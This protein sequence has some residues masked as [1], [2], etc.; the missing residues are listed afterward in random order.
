LINNALT[1]QNLHSRYL[2]ESGEAIPRIPGPRRL[3]PFS[4]S[5]GLMP[6]KSFEKDK[7]VVIIGAGLAGLTAGRL[8]AEAR[9]PYVILEADGRP[10]GLCRTETVNGFSFD[11]TG[12]LLHLK[13]GES[14]DIILGMLGQHLD[15][16]AR[17]ASVFIEGAPVPYPIQAHFGALPAP[18]AKR[19]MEDL[20]R[21]RGSRVSP[22]MAFPEWARAQF[23]ETL[24]DIFMIPYNQKLFIHPLEEMEISWTSWS[25]P[26]PTVKEVKVIAAGGKPP[27]FG[28]NATFFY[29]R[30]GGIEILPGALGGGQEDHIRNGIRVRKVNAARKTVT[31][32]GGGEISYRYLINTMPLPDF[33]GISEGLDEGFAEAGRRFRHCSVMGLCIGLDGRVLR[34]D[35]WIY[36]PGE[37]L[38]FYRVGFPSNFSGDAA[39]EGC[40]SLYAEAAYVPGKAPDTDRLAETVVG[41][42]KHYGIIGKT[43]KVAA[44][45]DL[46]IPC[47]YVFHDRYRAEKL[48]L[49]LDRLRAAQIFSVGRYG[50][51]E[52]SAMQ[53]A[54]EWGIR[55][56]R[57]VLS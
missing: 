24:A 12:H 3:N 49:V 14:R 13:E 7:A 31:V 37:D 53:D 45:L 56:A 6:S 46:T 20:M 57:E 52:Y 43:A 4:R 26:R 55:T 42:L 38:P 17:R 27:S 28:Y 54:V 9:V 44:R 34:D 16:H 29:P 11:Y 25:V 48:G 18:L 50:A 36:F 30:R 41:S 33:I 1:R 35:H 8:L 51:W 22:E 39:P 23:G 32:D 10:G 5:W 19:C 47:A 40:G 2:R 15:E 21:A